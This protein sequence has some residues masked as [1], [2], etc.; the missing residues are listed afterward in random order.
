MIHLYSDTKKIG[1][2]KFAGEWTEMRE[3]YTEG[4]YSGPNW[5]MLYV[6]TCEDPN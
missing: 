5:H 2:M 1:T 6:R 4:G 3:N